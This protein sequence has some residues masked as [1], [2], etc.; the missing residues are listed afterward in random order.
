MRN[1]SKVLENQELSKNLLDVIKKYK[2]SILNEFDNPS[3]IEITSVKVDINNNNVYLT[4][5]DY[6]EEKQRMQEILFEVMNLKQNLQ[7]ETDV[8]KKVTL[9]N[10]LTKLIEEYDTIKTKLNLNIDLYDIV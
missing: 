9:Q 7:N 2:D 10:R 6:T 5:N 3:T 4:Y 1:E 8:I